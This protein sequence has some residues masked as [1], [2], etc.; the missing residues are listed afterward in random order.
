MIVVD[1]S[2]GCIGGSWVRSRLQAGEEIDRYVGSFVPRNEGGVVE[3]RG[4]LA[5]WLGVCEMSV[6]GD[7]DRC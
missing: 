1:S 6:E 4:Y 2:I 7:D 3:V 5:K